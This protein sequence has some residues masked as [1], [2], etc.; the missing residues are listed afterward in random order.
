M[1]K[2]TWTAPRLTALRWACALG[3]AR[4]G[5]TRRC[6]TSPRTI[7]ACGRPAAKT[8]SRRRRADPSRHLRSRPSYISNFR[9]ARTGERGEL[10]DRRL[11]NPILKPWVVDALRKANDEHR[12]QVPCYTRE[13]R[14]WAIRRSRHA[15]QIRAAA[16]RPDAEAGL[17]PPAVR[18]SGARIYLNQPPFG[19]SG[20]PGTENRSATTRAATRRG[21]YIGMNDRT[22]V[23]SYRTPPHRPDPRGGALQA[24]RGR[25]GARSQFHGRRSRRLSTCRGWRASGGGACRARWRRTPAREQRELFQLDT[26]ASCEHFDLP[27]P[28]ANRSRFRNQLSAGRQSARCRS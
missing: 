1:F 5:R 9:A 6:R 20:R 27:Q 13:A 4:G 8:S 25:Q 7:A 12:R 16:F 26:D 10:A 19:Q 14:C 3:G 17:D 18:P 11:T 28:T 23:D 2:F 21:R 15:A 24:D 22:F